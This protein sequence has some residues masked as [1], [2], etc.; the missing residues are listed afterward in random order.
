MQVEDIDRRQNAAALL[1]IGTDT[2]AM[3]LLV[4]SWFAAG[5][6]VLWIPIVDVGSGPDAIPQARVE[7]DDLG[8]PYLLQSIAELVRLPVGIRGWLFPAHL[9][10]T[11]VVAIHHSSG[12]VAFGCLRNPFTGQ[13]ISY[14]TDTESD[15]PGFESQV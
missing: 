9:D 15:I 12:E 8:K 11:V 7:A 2:T 14:R 1:P 6:E 3:E 4:M 10:D 13:T 5:H